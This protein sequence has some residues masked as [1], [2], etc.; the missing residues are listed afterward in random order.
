M[1]F[2]VQKRSLASALLLSAVLTACG[3]GNNAATPT[4]APPDGDADTRSDRRPEDV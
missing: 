2:S 4:P 3:G 1:K